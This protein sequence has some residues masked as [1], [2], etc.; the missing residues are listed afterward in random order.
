MQMSR[1]EL[2]QQLCAQLQQMGM[3]RQE[4]MAEA[5]YAL[6]FILDISVSDLLLHGTDQVTET[7]EEQLRQIVKKRATGCPLAYILGERYFMGKPFFVQPGVL[8]PRQET[9]LLCE[10]A[11]EVIRTQ[12]LRSV[13]DLCTGSGCIAISI[14]KLTDAEVTAL[15]ISDTA[16]QTAGRNAE[17]LQAK[18]QLLH[19]DLFLN[20]DRKY[21]M[22]TANPPY[23]TA[24]AYAQLEDNVRVY[25]PELALLGGDDGLDFYRRIAKEAPEY[26]NPGGYLVQEI[27]YDQGEAVR[28]LLAAQGFVN[29]EIRQDYAGLD[30]MVWANLPL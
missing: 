5:R 29:I 22:I 16:L 15:D 23:I 13:L 28:E 19:S 4:A 7:Q 10:Q 8:I 30:R 26:L 6:T 17:L 1:N 2:L 14:A 11:A 18:V 27:G 9:E 25:E 12:G 3:T 20:V 21:D 24:A